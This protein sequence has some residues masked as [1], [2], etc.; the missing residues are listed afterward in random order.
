M[1]SS[2]EEAFDLVAD[3]EKA[4]SWVPDLVS[5]NK[6]SDGEVGVGTRYAE[7]VQMGKN[8]GDAVLEITEYVAPR[9]FAFKGQGGPSRFT[10]RYVL[11]PAAD[12]TAITHHYSVRL[13]G[14][15]WL[16]SFV[17]NSW[18]RKNT[19]AGMENLKGLLDE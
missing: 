1:K 19:A 12:G 8:Q 10:G 14:I 16:F 5:M 11:E 13:T 4:P 2:P 6:V 7:V 15:M 18:V 9:I 17:T 3:L